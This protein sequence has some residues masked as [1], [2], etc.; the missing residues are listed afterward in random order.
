MALLFLYR[1]FDYC[2][3]FKTLNSLI[4]FKIAITYMNYLINS[5]TGKVSHGLIP[6]NLEL[7]SSYI[8]RVAGKG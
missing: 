3:I 4:F 5:D 1:T 2:Y 6:S 7:N 8:T